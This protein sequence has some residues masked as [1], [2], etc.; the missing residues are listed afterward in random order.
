MLLR[1]AGSLQQ[2][3]VCRREVPV[4]LEI[5]RSN[6]GK[7]EDSNAGRGICTVVDIRAEMEDGQG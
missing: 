2:M 5:M 4:A 1:A 7:E 6:K 3:D